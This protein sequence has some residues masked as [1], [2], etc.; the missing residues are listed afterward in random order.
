MTVSR[1]ASY[2]VALI[3]VAS[4]SVSTISSKWM[5]DISAVGR[6]CDVGD[7]DC[8][9][10]QEHLFDHP[11]VQTWFMFLGEFVCM[12]LV[13][14][15][16]F[17]KRCKSIE[18]TEGEDYM[19]PVTPFIFMIPALCD[20]TASTT[21]YVGLTLTAASVYQMLRGATVLFTGLLSIA[22]LKRKFRTFEWLG[23]FLV[24]GGL[25]CVGIASTVFSHGNSSG[26][27]PILGDI[28][29][30]G[31]QLIVSGQMVIE[32]K[33]LTKY[34]VP[35]M[36]LVGWEGTFGLFYASTALGIFQAWPKGGPSLNGHNPPDDFLDATAQMGNDSRLIVSNLLCVFAITFLNAAGQTITKNIS[37][38]ARMVLDTVRNVIVWAFC[39][40]IP[41]F[42]EKFQWLQLIGFLLLVCGNAIFKQIIRLPCEFFAPATES[43]KTAVA[44]VAI[45][46]GEW[47]DPN[48]GA[49]RPLLV[50]GT[51]SNLSTSSRTA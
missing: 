21:M 29:I 5:D 31:A 34:N 35:P 1:Y 24:T 13:Q 32:E 18:L 45:E 6:T 47:S 2:V 30:F 36:L 9:T 42:D 46:D 41:F 50:N 33:L 27:N 23:M 12:I 3:F 10:D 40:G 11:F 26:T 43:E 16:I 17:Y 25:L 49:K 51:S 37:A 39:L 44:E 4:G 48:V 15:T 8:K 28:L 38:T 20:F 7:H 22:F 19:K 14:G